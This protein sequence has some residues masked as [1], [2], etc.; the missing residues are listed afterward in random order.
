MHDKVVPASALWLI[1]DSSTFFK[2]NTVII[3]VGDSRLAVDSS[4]VTDNRCS[5]ELCV[6]LQTKFLSFS[7]VAA[8]KLLAGYWHC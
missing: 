6:L 7:L 5:N 2:K 8:W 1:G 3:T 4:T